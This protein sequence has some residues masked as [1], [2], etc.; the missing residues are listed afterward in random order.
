MTDE[1][2]ESNNDRNVLRHAHCAM[3]I[4]IP[5]HRL[6]MHGRSQKTIGELHFGVYSLILNYF[7]Y[8]IRIFMHFKSF[9]T[10]MDSFG[11]L[12]PEN[13]LNTS[14]GLGPIN[15]SELLVCLQLLS[16]LMILS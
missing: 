15:T 9:L 6:G 8:F 2:E 16:L 13:L 5:S 12:N 1:G 7:F 4:H 11:S 3:Q 14:I 10:G